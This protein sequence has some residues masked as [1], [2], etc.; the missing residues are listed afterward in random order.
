MVKDWSKVLL[1]SLI[2]IAFTLGIEDLKTFFMFQRDSVTR[3]EMARNSS[4]LKVETQIADNNIREEMRATTAS[5]DKRYGEVTVALSN[6]E[7]R[8][9]EFTVE[10]TG[11]R[12]EMSTK[13]DLILN[14]LTTKAGLGKDVFPSAKD[15]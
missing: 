14:L 4:D 15:N 2:G 13:I 5:L 1:G 11:N 10:S 7:H 6:L 9:N 8:F 3:M 12:K